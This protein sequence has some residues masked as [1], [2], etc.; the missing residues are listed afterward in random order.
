MAEDLVR[1]EDGLGVVAM[2]EDSDWAYLEESRRTV[3]WHGS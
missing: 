2:V 3:S 1:K